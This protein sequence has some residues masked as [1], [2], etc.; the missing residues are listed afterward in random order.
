MSVA[1]RLVAGAA[2]AAA[3]LPSGAARAVPP[4]AVSITA[5]IVCEYR[6]IAAQHPDSGLRNPD[7]LATRLCPPVLLPREYEAARDVIDL[8]PEAYA[9]Y[10]YVNARTRYIDALVENAAATGVAQVVVLGAGFDSRAYRFHDAHPGIVFFEVDLP[11]VIEAKKRAVA[12]A[13]G[14]VPRY[15][16]YAPIDFNTQSLA[17]VLAAAGYARE[18]RTLFIL[19][20][21]TMYVGEAGVAST[22]DFIAGG[23]PRGSRVV[24]DYILRR[25]AEGHYDR[26]YAARKEALGVARAGEPFV[27]GWTPQEAAEFARRHGLAVRE[28]LDA[29]AL[30]RRYLTGSDGK[31]DGRIPEWYRIIDAEVR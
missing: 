6:A 19:E 13:L 10:F 14:G 4:G 20:G 11:A 18:R 17:E 23:S 27:T 16:R 5:A 24:Y 15:V 25:V 30:T 29:A 31:P 22:L 21:V 8:D 7:T 12:R 1:V 26:M 2:L 3:L 9:S 28:D